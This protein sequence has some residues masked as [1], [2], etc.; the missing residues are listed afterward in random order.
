MT[1][2]MDVTE[3]LKSLAYCCKIAVASVDS[4]P[5]DGRA[6]IAELMPDAR[7]V[8]VLGH[9]VQASLEWVWYPFESERGGK[10]CGADLHARAAI[11]SIGMI[12]ESNGHRALILPYPTACG[13][14]FKRLAAGTDMG[15]M[16]YSFLFLHRE[17]GPWVHLR[18]LLTDADVVET[19]ALEEADVCLHCESCIEACPGQCLSIGNHDQETCRRFQQAEGERLGIGETYAYECEVCARACTLGDQPLGVVIHDGET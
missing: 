11:K 13:I 3:I 19:R 8:V 2:D 5:E 6:K 15:E 17:W 14:S 10:T 9:H 18:V 12:L 4:Y 16:G 1:G 7:T